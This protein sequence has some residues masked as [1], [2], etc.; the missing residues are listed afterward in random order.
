MAFPLFFPA[1][2]ANNFHK[3]YYRS[4]NWTRNTYLGHPILQ[5]PFDLLVYQE[6]VFTVRPRFIIQTGVAWGGSV[7]FLATMLDLIG[8][9]RDAVVIGI[10]IRLSR[11][12]REITHPRVRLVKGVA[13]PFPAPV[14]P[15]C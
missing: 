5:C 12:A 8:A 15:A 9:D 1:R 14:H 2:I 13:F 3:L 11:K 4:H 10:D 7:L 6:I